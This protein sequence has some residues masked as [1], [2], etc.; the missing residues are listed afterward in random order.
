MKGMVIWSFALRE[1]EPSPCNI[2]LAEAVK[3]ILEAEPDDLVIIS[4]W[5]VAKKLQEDGIEIYRIIEPF[6]DGSYLDS[7]DIWEVARRCFSKM[8]VEEI[9]G[10][11]NPFIHGYVVERMIKKDGFAYVSSHDYLVGK[12]GFDRLSLQWWTRGPIRFLIYAVLKA[13][14]LAK[15]FRR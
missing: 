6:S 4:Q 10:V 5:E 3:R 14:H 15:F 13:L 9:I 12:V 2:R 11:A 1:N 8:G 7:T